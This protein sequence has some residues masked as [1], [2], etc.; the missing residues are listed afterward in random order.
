VKLTDL[1]AH[2]YLQSLA[3]T[4]QPTEVHE[5]DG[6]GLWRV[7]DDHFVMLICKN[8]EHPAHKGPALL[9]RVLPAE[10]GVF[11]TAANPTRSTRS[12]TTGR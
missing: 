12:T 3:L 8:P 11:Y 10:W 9:R 1:D 2:D 5:M 7:A 6:G 4:E